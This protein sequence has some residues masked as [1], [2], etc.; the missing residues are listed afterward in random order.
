MTRYEVLISDEGS[1]A[2]DGSPLVPATG[3]SVHEAVLD[4]LQRYAVARDETVEA[5]VNEGPETGHFV[6]EVSP[7]GSSRVLPTT[8]TTT[9]VATA[10]ARATAA[11]RAA[12]APLAVPQTPPVVLPSELAARI[13]RINE[14]AVAGLLDEAHALATEL[15][16]SLTDEAGADDPH[17]VEARAV[18]AYIAH[19]RG[20][21]REAV[22]LALAVARIRC[23]AGDRRA[24]EEVA[25]AAAA[26]QWLDDDRAA[27]VHGRELLHMWDQLDGRGALPP[28][29]G[30]LAGRVRR[31]V[32]ELEAVHV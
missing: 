19:L 29:H 13:G 6:L 17:A 9:A 16:E 24:A 18:E 25:R 22:V 32:D 31:R 3:Q 14:L 30:E 2:I 10:V 11:A 27:A 12:T 28:V 15:R 4:Q 23:R 26:W 8:S 7:D 21:H 5:T 1:A 20:D